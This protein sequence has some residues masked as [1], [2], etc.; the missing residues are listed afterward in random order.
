MIA[1]GPL[2][3][4][5]HDLRWVHGIGRDGGDGG[6][7]LDD[8][9]VGASRNR[10]VCDADGGDLNRVLGGLADTTVGSAGVT[11]MVW[12][13]VTLVQTS[14]RLSRAR[15]RASAMGKILRLLRVKVTVQVVPIGAAARRPAD[16]GGG[17]QSRRRDRP[18]C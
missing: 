4:R 6:P 12:E 10:G 9:C 17:T 3:H 1:P 16:G 5:H 13:Y 14:T 15:L 2:H 11:V 7:A 8:I 18:E